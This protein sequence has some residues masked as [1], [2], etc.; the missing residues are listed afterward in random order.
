MAEPSAMDVILTRVTKN[1]TLILRAAKHDNVANG[2]LAYQAKS[3]QS[4]PAHL[5]AH[6]GSSRI[7]TD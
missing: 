1:I 7:A 6:G 5:A 2:H 4:T 3:S